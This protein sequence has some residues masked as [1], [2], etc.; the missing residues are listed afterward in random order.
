MVFQTVYH[1]FEAMFEKAFSKIDQKT[2]PQAGQTKIGQKLLRVN[3]A[4][5]WRM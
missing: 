3:R 4:M 2:Q 1:A 5:D